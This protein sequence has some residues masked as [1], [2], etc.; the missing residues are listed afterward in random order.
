M[1]KQGEK[2]T[3]SRTGQIMIFIKTGH[4]TNGELLE[5]ECFSPPSKAREPEHIHPYQENNF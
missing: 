4:E 2:I 1:A 3:N 5:I